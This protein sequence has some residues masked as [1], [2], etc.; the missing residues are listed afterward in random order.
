MNAISDG[1]LAAITR[2][3]RAAQ[4]LPPVIEDP[5]VLADIAR[6]AR[7]FITA[8]EDSGDDAA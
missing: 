2:A 7:P 6:I 4:G 5:G 3:T 8:A 1:Q